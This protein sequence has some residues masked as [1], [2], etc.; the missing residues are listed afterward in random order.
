MYRLN[1]EELAIVDTARKVV[2]EVIRPNAE[3][4]DSQSQFPAAG[5]QALGDSGLMGLTISKDFGGMGA[6]LRCS[7]AVLDEVAQACAS[8][9]MVYLMH[10]C[11]L[12]VYSAKPEVAGDH[13]REAAKGKHLTTLAWSEAGSR[14]HFWAPVS[15]S[16]ESEGQITLNAKKSWVT[17]AGHADGYVATTGTYS[18]IDLVLVLKSDDGFSVAGPWDALGMRGNASAP[19]TLENCKVPTSRRLSE[20]DQAFGMMMGIVLPQFQLGNAAV[21]VGVAEGAV[22]ATAKHLTGNKFEHLGSKLAD[23]PNL[24]V[25][26]AQMRIET[27]KARALLA[28]SIDAAESGAPTA[29][30]HILQSKAMA[31]DAAMDVTDLAMKACG[32]AA[33]SKQLG[34]ERSF[35]DARAMSVM[36]PTSDVLHDFIGKAL[37]GMELF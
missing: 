5:L 8:T 20:P 22:Q 29:M 7:A 19:M 18:G 6:G 30:L 10:L 24:R 28:S 37:C 11:G 35:R 3:T 31:G 26:L 9:A 16:T 12:T 14:S 2:N 33:F 1:S 23:L 13:L 32:G 17:S 34:I 25:R 36:A 27:D 21:S 15:R 4:V